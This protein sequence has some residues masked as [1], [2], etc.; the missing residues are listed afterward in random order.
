MRDYLE[1]DLEAITK[2]LKDQST[3]LAK[4]P[5]WMGEP[6]PDERTLAQADHYQGDFKRS[7]E[8]GH[9]H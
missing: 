5:A 3:I 7:L 1:V 6:V 8:C 9:V 4:T 2:Q